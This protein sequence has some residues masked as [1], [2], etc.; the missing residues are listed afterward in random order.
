MSLGRYI[1][2]TPFFFMG[3]GYLYSCITGRIKYQTSLFMSFV[4]TIILVQQWVNYGEDKW[5][6]YY[7]IILSIS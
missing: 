4:S 6:V 1:F 3:L 7:I 2:S 5:L